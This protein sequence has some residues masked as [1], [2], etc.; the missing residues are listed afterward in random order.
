MKVFIKNKLISLGGSSDILNENQEPVFRVD[1]KVV[2]FTRTKEMFDMEGKL[3]Y[4]IRNRYFNFLSD[5]V[6]VYNAEGVKVAT[7]KKNKFS[8]NLKY[9]ILDSESEMS[10]EGKF[11]KGVSNII[12]NGETVA[13]ITRDFSIL[14]DAYILEAE[15]KD[16]AFYTALVIAF[17]NMLDQKD[18][19]RH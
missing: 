19:D 13:T 10:I 6:Y 16:I 3:L 14:N 17:D 18:S 4:T 12:K 15:D 7:L 9:Q 2:T 8:F 1:G 5:K 11:F